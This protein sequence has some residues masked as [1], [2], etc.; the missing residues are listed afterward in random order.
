MRVTLKDVRNAVIKLLE[1]KTEIFEDCVRFGEYFGE[2]NAEVYVILENKY[3]DEEEAVQQ[4]LEVT[5]TALDSNGNDLVFVN[6]SHYDVLRFCE[7]VRSV[8]NWCSL[9]TTLER[10]D[11]HHV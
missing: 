11:R 9:I 5:F 2:Y 8:I 3:P 10:C 7:D 6:R 4:I 1:V